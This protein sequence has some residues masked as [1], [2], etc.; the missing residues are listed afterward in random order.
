MSTFIVHSIP[1]SPFARSVMATLEEKGASW[2][3]SPLTPGM[4]REPA[5]LERHPF[6]R[7]PVLDHDGFQL[8]EAQ[9]ILRYLDRVLPEPPLTP[10][11]AHAA[12]RMDQV[13][14]INDWYLFQGC[15]NI[16]VFQRVIGPM[17]AG[18]EP[19]L[20]A[21]ADAMP[22]AR[23]VFGELAKLLGDKPWFA[24]DQIS[25]ADLLVGP[26]L[27]LFA[28]APEWHELVAEAP[29]LAQFLARIEARPAMQRTRM[30]RL[31]T[32]EAA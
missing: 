23:T 5:H 11:D 7:M 6:G 31:A 20:Q 3:L 27:E 26:Q 14:N 18:L 24:G 8:Y 19:D 4:L 22:R 16:I 17:L 32:L 13:M 25:L 28:R 9:A 10:A 12:A 30:E 2:R 1:G 21:I 15:A 29:N